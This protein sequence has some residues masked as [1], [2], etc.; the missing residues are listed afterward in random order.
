MKLLDFDPTL[1][2]ANQLD[3]HVNS[4]S[5]AARRAEE[6]STYWARCPRCGRRQARENLLEN[7]CFVCAWQGTEEEIHMAKIKQPSQSER[8]GASQERVPYRTHCPNCG[9]LVVTEQLMEKGC[10]ICRWKPE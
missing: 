2:L 10:Y 3:K 1:T 9:A 7:G 5:E 6:S 4:Q 8:T